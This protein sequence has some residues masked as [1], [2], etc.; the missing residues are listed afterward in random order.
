[1]F[2]DSGFGGIWGVGGLCGLGLRAW[3]SGFS[4]SCCKET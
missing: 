1:M 2:S 3:G 4:R